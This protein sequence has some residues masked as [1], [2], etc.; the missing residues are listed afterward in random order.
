[1]MIRRPPDPATLRAAWWAQR[2]LRAA[3]RALAA[4]RMSDIVLPTPPALPA[5]KVRGVEALLRRR[6]HS[7]LEG[8]L[9][10]QRWLAAHGEVHE[11]AIG[12]TSPASG[13]AAHAWVIGAD[14]ASG[15]GFHE[16][17]RLRP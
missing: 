10:R 16:L 6:R 1:M 11:I 5:G 4:G 14:D 3:R 7:C 12:V 13:F 15:A 17:T 8:A 9:V 2:A